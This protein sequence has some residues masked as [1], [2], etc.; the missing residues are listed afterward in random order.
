[1]FNAFLVVTCALESLMMSEM[2]EPDSYCSILSSYISAAFNF[3]FPGCC[4]HFH[5]DKPLCLQHSQS[6]KVIDFLPLWSCYQ[7]CSATFSILSR[8]LA[9][10]LQYNRQTCFILRA[11]STRSS[12][13]IAVCSCL[14]MGANWTKTVFHCC[15]TGSCESIYS[16]TAMRQN[17]P[18]TDT[19]RGL[20]KI[21]MVHSVV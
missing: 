15:L 5:V 13:F 16:L 2:F 14:E 20:R 18:C 8:E 6:V 4:K 12:V 21:D 7:I 17:G 9:E 19:S 3:T 10:M 11:Y 1:M